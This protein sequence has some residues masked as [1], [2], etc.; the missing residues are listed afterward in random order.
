MWYIYIMEYFSATKKNETKSFIEMWM[1][2]ES[3]I[4]SEVVR[5]RKTSIIY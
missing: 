4:Q 5:K 1:D 3:V 2:R